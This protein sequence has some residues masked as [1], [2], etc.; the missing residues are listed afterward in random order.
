MQAGSESRGTESE[1]AGESKRPGVRGDVDDVL[2]GGGCEIHSRE[3]PQMSGVG[4]AV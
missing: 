1:A 3:Y 2:G 4:M